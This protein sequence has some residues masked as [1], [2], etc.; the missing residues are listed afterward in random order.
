[1]IAAGAVKD[2]MNAGRPRGRF[3]CSRFPATIA[4][5]VSGSAVENGP[6][7]LDRV[8]LVRPQAREAEVELDDRDLGIELRELLEA[9]ERALR[10][11]G[12]RRADFRLERVVL[13][14]ERSR[15]LGLAALI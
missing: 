1:M 7:R 4:Y 5:G 14:E 10:P 13:R 15:P 2:G 11:G 6:P 12:E 8:A 9:V 3:G